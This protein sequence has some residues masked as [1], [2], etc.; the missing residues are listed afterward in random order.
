MREIF[1][2]VEVTDKG[3]AQE[4]TVS[5][6]IQVKVG[7]RMNV[8]SVTS[9]CRSFEEFASE[10]EALKKELETH[11]ESAGIL[12]QG[13]SS[14]DEMKVSDD[15]TPEQIWSA[16]SAIAEEERFV[17]VFNALK[18]ERRREVAEYVLTS[19]NV[20]S[21]KAAVFSARYDSDSS[22]LE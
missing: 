2:L 14:K 15:M 12:F 11:L 22:F 10:M 6:G 9:A 8:L 19:C 4:R 5:L 21:G 18:V 20:F 17:R 16:L 1:Q 7:E 13:R 3:A